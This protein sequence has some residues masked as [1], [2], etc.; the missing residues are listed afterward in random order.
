M[1][2]YPYSYPNPKASET[3]IEV[4]IWD[5]CRSVSYPETTQ[6]NTNKNM[7]NGENSD[8]RDHCLRYCHF[9]A[10]TSPDG[11]NPIMNINS[12]ASSYAS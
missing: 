2:T 10:K 9:E 8:P 11:G 6:Q 12:Y 3:I 7:C 1:K 4:G 5:I